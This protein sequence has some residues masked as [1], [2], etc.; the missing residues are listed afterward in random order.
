MDEA[1][2]YFQE[3]YDILSSR[4]ET[5][6]EEKKL[7][8]DLILEW[9]LVFYYRCDVKG[10]KNLFESHRELAESIDDQERLAMF[11]AWHGF[12]FLS[13]DNKKAMTLLQKA[14]EIG[15]KLKNLKLIGYA[16]TWLTWVCSDLSRYDEALQYGAR[17]QEVSGILKSDHYL[18]FKS[19]GAMGIS[20]WNLGDSKQLFKIG[21]NL[22]EYGKKH[23]NIRSQTMGHMMLGGANNLIGNHLKVIECFKKAR[24]VTADT[25]YEIS[26]K[27]FIGLGY[28]LNEQIELAEPP[29]VEVVDF[30]KEHEW[31]WAGMPGQ[32]F[33]GTVMIAKGNINKGFKMIDE[34]H[35][36]FFREGRKYYIA[37]TEYILGKIYSQIVEGSSSISPLNIAKN[38]GFLVKTV[39]FADKKADSQFNKAIE[40]ANEIGAR[41]I[42]GPTYL[43]WGLLHKIKKRNDRARKC[44]SKAIEIFEQCEAEVYLKQANQAHESLK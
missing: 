30:T 36:S 42:S 24:E 23:A 38:I 12:V 18:Y 4:P 15:E 22:V 27:S 28:I 31:D 19:L 5:S 35:Q 6:I 8:I 11:Y 40:I 43:D 14:L 33:L 10:W 44:I 34:A 41:S 39:P 29:L 13:E 26:A 1:H 37:L 32:L 16:C 25:M 7:I 21:K 9:A 17:A 3:A 2:R 20:Y